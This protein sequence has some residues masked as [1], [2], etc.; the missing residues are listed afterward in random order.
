MYL[1]G[2]DLGTSSVKCAIVDAAT[3]RCVTSDF[4]PK[5]EAPIKSLKPGWAEQSPESWIDSMKIVTKEILAKSGIDAADIKAI[6]FSYQM[7]GLVAVDKQGNVLRDAIIWCDSRGVPYGD[8]AFKVLGA[9]T[10]LTHLLNNPGNFTAAKL[11]WVK[12]NEPEVYDRIYKVM[13]P[14]DY[15]AYR[16]SGEICTNPEGLSEYMLWDFKDDAPARLL[17]DYYGFDPDIFPEVRPT[18]CVQGRVS[19]RAAAEFG[20]AEG[21]PI[22]YKAGDQP[23]NALSLNVFNPGEVASTA[24]TSGV[25]YGINDKIDYDRLSRVNNFAHVNH[26]AAAPRIGVMTCINGTGILNSWIKKNVAPDGITYQQM[27]DLA[28][29]VPVGSCG[30]SILPFGNGAERVLGNRTTG[31]SF[32]GIHFNIHDRRHILRA[33]QEGIVFSLMYGMEIMQDMGLKIN[34][35]HAGNANM[36]LSPVFRDTLA[37]VSG[38][39]IEL[40]DTD[41]AAGAAK[42]AGMGIGIYRDNNEAFATLEKIDEIFPAADRSP[43]IEAYGRW[44]DILKQQL[45]N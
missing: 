33:A 29:E 9:D 20:L 15:A 18:F 39:V 35:I 34:R 8:K 14:A 16:L 7:H 38:A 12:E 23:N 37:S 43:Y 26:T 3:G 22:A 42:G 10:C 41:G 32:H 13:L 36:F 4:Y 5:T 45:D 30:V 19:A 24:G 2:Y 28:A 25:V 40:Y 6:G 31:C 11:R 27:N 17:M 44:K 21:T 1:L